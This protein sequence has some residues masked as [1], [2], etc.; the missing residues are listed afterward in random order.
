MSKE[1]I[2]RKYL[3]FKTN[4]VFKPTVNFFCFGG[5]NL[6]NLFHLLKQDKNINIRTLG[7]DSCGEIS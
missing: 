3:D 7:L 2:Q 6:K 1:E 5:Q 4:H